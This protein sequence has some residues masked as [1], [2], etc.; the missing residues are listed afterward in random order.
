MTRDHDA[1]TDWEERIG[2]RSGGAARGSR[3]AARPARLGDAPSRAAGQV[4]LNWAPCRGAI[5]YQVYGADSRRRAGAGRPRAAATC[6]RVPHPPYVD[7][8]GAA[9]SERCY[10]VATLSDVAVEGEPSE[11]VTATSLSDGGTGRRSR[12]TRPVTVGALARPWRPM[13]GSEHLSHA[14]S[15]RRD[16]RAGDRR[17]AV[18][19][20]CARRTSSSVCRRVRAHGILCDD[21]GG[22]PRGRRRAGARL[23]R[24]RPGLRPHPLARALRRSSRC[25]SCR[26]TWRATRPRRSSTTARSCRRPRTGT[27]GTT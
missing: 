23:H 17:G 5:G 6:S 27:A 10:A 24:C 19:P 4:T 7:T 12:W 16:R 2:L 26:T 11:R 1:R 22:L 13:I 21:L 3:T 15:T 20:R 8:T 14:L 25:R 18:A 9:G